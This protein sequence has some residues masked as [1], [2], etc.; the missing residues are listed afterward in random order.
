MCNSH[1]DLT[2]RHWKLSIHTKPLFICRSVT[3]LILAGMAFVS[4]GCAYEPV[5]YGPPSHNHYYPHD[6]DYSFYPSARVYFHFSTGYYFYRVN[7]R[8]V[9]SHVLPS[10]IHLS[11]TDRVRIRVESDKP[12]SRYDE[13]LRLYEPRTRI[14]VD[15]EK[16]VKE[17]EANRLWFNEYQ[18]KKE[19]PVYKPAKKEK[20]KKEKRYEK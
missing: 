8:W 13:H 10:H 12:Y 11:I 14:R 15:R 3:C 2:M 20:D 5:Y 9:K 6:Y 19:K 17:R 7:G 4:A 1:D 18:K 16:S